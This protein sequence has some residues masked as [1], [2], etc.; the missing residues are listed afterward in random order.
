[1]G[2][3]F[4]DIMEKLEIV[5]RENKIKTSNKITQLIKV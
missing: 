1:M 2:K 3:N 5:W 4:I